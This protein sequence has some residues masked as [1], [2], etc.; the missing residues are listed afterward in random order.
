MIVGLPYW[1][2]WNI[3]LPKVLGYELVPWKERLADGTVVTRV[4]LMVFF[5]DR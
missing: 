1:S 3:V 4:S 5:L 2:A